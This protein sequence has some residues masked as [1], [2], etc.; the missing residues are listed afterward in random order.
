MLEEANAYREE[1]VA[2]A[3]GEAGRF[4]KLL[5]EYSKAP[6]VTRERMYLDA[7]T[8]VMSKST[9]VLMDVEGGNNIMYLPLDQMVNRS[10]SGASFGGGSGLD[11]NSVEQVADEV[12]NRLRRRQTSTVREER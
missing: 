11:G 12:I 5:T 4:E 3:Q 10:Q 7:V 6:E 8:T 1:V 2:R 9:K